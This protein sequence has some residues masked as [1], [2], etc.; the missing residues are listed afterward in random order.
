M[1]QVIFIAEFGD[2]GAS[3]SLCLHNIKHSLE[4]TSFTSQECSGPHM[5][6]IHLMEDF[7]LNVL[8]LESMCRVLSVSCYPI[9]LC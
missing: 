3:V 8:L 7:S 6:V 5:V 2:P 4:N 9:V 1:F